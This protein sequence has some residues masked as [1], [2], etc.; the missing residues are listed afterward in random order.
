[1]INGARTSQEGAGLADAA[2]DPAE[3]APEGGL[4]RNYRLLWSAS[5]LG[6]LGDGIGRVA[7][8]LLAAGLTRDP[9]L[10]AGVAVMAQLPWLLF[11]LP[12]GAIVDRADRRLAMIA[13]GT[14]RAAII[15]VFTVLVARDSAGILLLYVAALLVGTAET[16]YDTAANTLLPS[17]VARDSLDTA[18]GRLE[19]VQVISQQFVGPPV[20]GA[21]FAS[22][23]AAPFVA[24]SIFLTAGALAVSLIRGRFRAVST[25]P[26]SAL[27][28]EIREGVSWLAREPDLRVVAIVVAVIGLV[29]AGATAV[30]VLYALEVVNV[31]SRGF[32]V[33]VAVGAV[34]GVCGG[35][36]AAVLTRRLGRARAMTL[37]LATAGAALTGMALVSNAVAAAAL[38]ALGSGAMVAWN[39]V[40]TTLRQSLTPDHLL[41][42]VLAAYRVLAWGSM[43]LGAALGGLV[44]RTAGLRVPFL[45]AGVVLLV[46]AIATSG[47][48]ART[49][50]TVSRTPER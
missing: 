14:V 26:R 13:A 5:A 8:P 10:I 20:G 25:A 18:N 27:W 17:I 47:R 9:L 30:L 43:A 49:P 48:F 35:L 38:L 19:G 2:C 36:G 31:G 29:S 28:R 7:F 33:I 34:G 23:V 41:G 12:A 11:A 16:V 42:R 1:M 37:A 21:L 15:V 40:T 46:L 44:A 24:S 6:N 50:G 22:A 3:P 32:G 39:V 45:L 4:G